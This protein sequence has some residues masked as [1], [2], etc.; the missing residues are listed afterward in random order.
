MNDSAY[1]TA[2]CCAECGVEGGVSLKVCKSCMLVRYC[3]ANC[4]RNHW[5]KHKKECKIRAAELRD[6]AL[7]KD[8]P[9][10]EDCQICFLPMP[11]NLICCISLPPATVS[12]VPIS[13]YAEA[14]EEL[15]DEDT[16][17]Y[18]PC[19]GK[20]ICRGCIDSFCRSGNVYKC[21]Y[22]K[23]ERGGKTDEEMVEEI[24]KLVEVND[25]VAMG[26]L[27]NSYQDGRGG[28][29]QDRAKATELYAKAADLGYSK[30]H[31]LLG[32]EYRRRGDMKKAKF[33]FEAAATAGHEEAR[34]NVGGLEAQSGNMERAIKHWTIAASAGEYNA[35][36]H[37]ITLFKQ[38]VV[39]RDSINSTLTSYNNS[40]AEMRSESRN[41]AIRS[42]AG[43][44]TI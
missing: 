25:P 2:H 36:N 26:M 14:N 21:P 44:G 4:Q 31:Y 42:I 19:C 16:E 7:F 20:S 17:A 12:S 29:Q 28:L 5:P 6:E 33:H 35:M 23:A 40:C 10:K 34:Y 24:M 39:S 43:I 13:D 38:G 32:C 1:A 15:A 18:Y 9:A 8:P 37:L 22:C 3:N 41:A 11:I 27:A 30:A